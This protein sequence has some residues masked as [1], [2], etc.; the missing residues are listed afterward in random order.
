VKKST[1]ST[2]LGILTI[3]Y[4]I[5]KTSEITPTYQTAVWIEDDKGQYITS[6]FI[7]EWLSL[8]GYQYTNICPTWNKA[9]G[10]TGSS[11]P[12]FD[13]ITSATPDFG[14]NEVVID[15][16]KKGFVKGTYRYHVETHLTGEYNIL[17]S[18]EIFMGTES[19]NSIA[20]GTYIPD[21]Y[22]GVNEVLNNVTAEYKDVK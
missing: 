20:T 11:E 15:C 5:N 1:G 18:G 3:S 22:S 6:C 21:Q 9:S 13:A 8:L 10:W 2:I 4:Q 19:P 17:Y 16:E 12:E 14:L 7:S